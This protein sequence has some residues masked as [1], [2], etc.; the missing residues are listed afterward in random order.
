MTLYSTLVM[1]AGGFSA[2][3]VQDTVRLMHRTAVEGER[4]A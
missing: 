4:P 3:V 2:R 1:G